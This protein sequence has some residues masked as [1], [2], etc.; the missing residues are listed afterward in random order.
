MTD[1]IID[2][3]ERI[4]KFNENTGIH[5]QFLYDQKVDVTADEQKI[6][7][8]IYNFIHNAISYSNGSTNIEVIQT[9]EQ[10]EVKIA[11][12]DHGIGISIVKGILECHQFA[13]G[14]ESQLGKGSTFWFKMPIS[15]K[16]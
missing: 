6:E 5:I 14:V 11:V 4:Q 15:G 16:K 2:I 12:V 3:V 7:Q 13:Y 8:V 1:D 9:I 10:G